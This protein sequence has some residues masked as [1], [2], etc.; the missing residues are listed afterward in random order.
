[1][2]VVVVVAEK[3]KKVNGR[4]RELIAELAANLC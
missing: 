4:A 1:M 2:V 3:E